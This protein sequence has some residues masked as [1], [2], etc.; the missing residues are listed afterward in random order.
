MFEY[1]VPRFYS[2][3]MP[4]RFKG[5]EEMYVMGRELHEKLGI[6]GEY[7]KWFSKV[8]DDYAEG[9][10]Y[11]KTT[12]EGEFGRILSDHEL[13]Y[14]MA[15]HIGMTQLTPQGKDIREKLM[16]AFDELIA[17]G[18][19]LEVDN[20]AFSTLVYENA[21]LKKEVLNLKEE[22]R[23]L[24]REIA[25]WEAIPFLDEKKIPE[26]DLSDLYDDDPDWWKN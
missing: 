11:S 4:I 18:L 14:E 7:T 15:M 5:P 3:Y 19:S 1:E 25:S 12:S 13:S 24:K 9:I 2:N 17:L 6:K 23:S 22:V 8:K 26:L 16:K 10:D 20:E 21:D